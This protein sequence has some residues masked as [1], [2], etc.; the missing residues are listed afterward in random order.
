MKIDI[1]GAE[2][3][4]F[5]SGRSLLSDSLLGVRTEVS[6]IPIYKGQP[7]W[8]DID[9][10]LQGY[11]FVPMGFPELHAWRRTTKTKFPCLADGPL[12]YS[13]GQIV[14]GDVL[15]FRHPETIPDGNID[16][17]LKAAFLAIAFEYIDHAAAIFSKPNVSQ[18]L[19]D[20]FNVDALESLSIISVG[21][22]KSCKKSN[23]SKI[24]GFLSS[25]ANR[26]TRS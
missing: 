17:L 3:E 7:L 2:L 14:H 24:M 10:A 25:V 22:A 18:Y 21:L 23:F 15:Y 8:G 26:L 6:F 4:V 9:Q 20:K 12:P 19:K 5:S 13:K 1:Q 11:G 16:M